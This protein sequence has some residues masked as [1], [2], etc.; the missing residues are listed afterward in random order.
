MFEESHVAKLRLNECAYLAWTYSTVEGV[1]VS[2]GMGVGEALHCRRCGA[3]TAH[4]PSPRLVRDLVLF[5][6]QQP[7]RH[8]RLAR[9]CPRDSG[10]HLETD[11]HAVDTERA[12]SR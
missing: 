9:G 2:M 1:G 10:E 7:A 11:R 4:H 6:L 12:W 5:K 3:L 8:E